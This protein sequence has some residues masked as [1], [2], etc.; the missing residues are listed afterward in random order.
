M[1]SAGTFHVHTVHLDIIRVSY[2][3]TDAQVNCLKKNFK[4]YIKF[5]IKTALIYFGEISI[6]R[7]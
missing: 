2:S 6:I 5:G 3:P 7:E 4:I 1:N